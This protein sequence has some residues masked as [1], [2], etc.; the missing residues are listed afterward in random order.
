[1]AGNFEGHSIPHLQ[2]LPDGDDR[3]FIDRVRPKL[4]EA[5][6]KRIPPLTDSKVL[7]AWNGLMISAFARAALWLD[8]EDY[9]K[10]AEA[11][12]NF[13][14][15]THLKDGKLLRTSRDGVAKH[16]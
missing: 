9:R 8:R 3:A 15:E 4:Y 5:R 13:I 12:A 2:A 11:A 1:E 14:V 10:R 16:A 6:K 7:T